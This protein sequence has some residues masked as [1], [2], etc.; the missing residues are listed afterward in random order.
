MEGQGGTRIVIGGY[1]W[2]TWGNT[3]SPRY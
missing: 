1:T 3:R 2:W